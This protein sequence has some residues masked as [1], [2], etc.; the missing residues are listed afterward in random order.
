MHGEYRLVIVH[1]DGAIYFA[2]DKACSNGWCMLNWASP[3]LVNQGYAMLMTAMAQ[4]KL[5]YLAW[6]NM[7][8]CNSVNAANASPD[9]MALSP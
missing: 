3:T 7:P 5:V 4:G 1:Q 6:D 2:T 9:F 8:H